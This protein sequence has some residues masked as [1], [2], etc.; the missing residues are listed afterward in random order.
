M[1]PFT[2]DAWG[3]TSPALPTLPALLQLG[4]KVYLWRAEWVVG[5]SMTNGVAITDTGERRSAHLNSG[6]GQEHRHRP[7]TVV[8]AKNNGEL[9]TESK[10][11]T[12]TMPVRISGDLY[13]AMIIQKGGSD[14]VHQ[15]KQ[16]LDKEDVYVHWSSE[17]RNQFQACDSPLQLAEFSQGFLILSFFFMGNVWCGIVSNGEFGGCLFFY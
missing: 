16:Q 9:T 2:M 11:P 17:M 7:K 5:D 14:E 1:N 15:L 13:A 6:R 8:E 12:D 4:W 3:I 10:L